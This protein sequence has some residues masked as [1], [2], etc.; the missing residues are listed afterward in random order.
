[1]PLRTQLFVIALTVILLGGYLVLKGRVSKTTIKLLNVGEVSTTSLGLVTLIVGAVL[2]VFSIHAVEKSV[3][4]DQNRQVQE[5]QDSTSTA[6]S[7]TSLI[8]SQSSTG[9]GSPNIVNGGSV[10]VQVDKSRIAQ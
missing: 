9:D 5:R 6:L 4:T 3:D 2:A 7:A 8:V 1:M 10:T